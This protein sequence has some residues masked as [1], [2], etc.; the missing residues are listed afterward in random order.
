MITKPTLL[1]DENKCH[2]N[3]RFMAEKAN[4]NGV[5][6]RPHFKTHQSLEIGRWFRDYGVEKIT[7]SSLDMA[8]YFA[9]E[10]DD[11]TVA[12]PV[13]ILEIDTINELA[14]RIRL[15]ILVESIE[16]IEFLMDNL[17]N[18]VGF[19]IKIDVGT[20]RTGIDP[21]DPRIIDDMLE[22]TAL[23]S[24]LSFR[25]FLAHAGHTYQCRSKE[26]Y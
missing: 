25:G 2:R 13:N 22:F 6:L 16:A 1:L 18:E 14:S 5:V 15:N 20:H 9:V 7:V 11:I 23:S 24:K 10:W 19:F 12:F 4:K 3:I 8:G 26:S 17:S 21:S